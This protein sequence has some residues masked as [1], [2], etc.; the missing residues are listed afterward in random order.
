MRFL[1]SSIIATGLFCAASGA[2]LQAQTAQPSAAEA[3]LRESLR[4]T[5]LQLR[6]VENEKAVLDAAKTEAEDKV[7]ALTAQVEEITKK[8]AA[9]KTAADKTATELQVKV[10]ERDKAIAELRDGLRGEMAERKKA[11]EYGQGKEAQRAKLEE[12]T[13]LLNRRVADQQTKNAAMFKIANEILVRYEKFGLGDALTAREP[14]TGITRVKL[15]SLFE[16]YQDKLVDQRIKPE[17]PATPAPAA[18]TLPKATAAPAP[19]ATP[20][21]KSSSAAKKPMKFKSASPDPNT[22]PPVL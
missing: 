11:V 13:I 15:Q 18:A 16:E 4:A 5:M 3:K 22:Q 19:K 17:A 7:K 8:M 10:E 20:A 12:Q 6:N 21:S 1:R 2:L 9:D 14:F